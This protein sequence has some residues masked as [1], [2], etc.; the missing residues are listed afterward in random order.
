MSLKLEITELT[1]E[2]PSDSYG[3]VA[4]HDL[5]DIISP[6]PHSQHAIRRSKAATLV[7]HIKQLLGGEMSAGH[8][9][10]ALQSDGRRAALISNIV[11]DASRAVLLL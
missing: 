9:D 8:N 6:R 4:P 11:K 1:G 5:A 7:R 10:D 2:K 3:F